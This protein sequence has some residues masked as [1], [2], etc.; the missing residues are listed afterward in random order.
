MRVL[1]KDTVLL[2]LTEVKRNSHFENN[3]PIVTVP[4]GHKITLTDILK[5][6]PFQKYNQKVGFASQ[7]INADNH[8]PLTILSFVSLKGF[9]NTA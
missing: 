3:V 8:V 2:A 6:Y 5:G 4:A 7:K 9:L 1:P